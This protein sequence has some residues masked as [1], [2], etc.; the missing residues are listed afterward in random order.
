[1]NTTTNKHKQLNKAIQTLK[2]NRREPPEG[3]EHA[4]QEQHYNTLTKYN[5]KQTILLTTFNFYNYK[6]K[7]SRG[8]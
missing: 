1:M 2:H 3:G 5:Y 4:R 8:R 6:Y 7:Y